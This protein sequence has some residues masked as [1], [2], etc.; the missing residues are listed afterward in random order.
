[1][2][3]TII[4]RGSLGNRVTVPPGVAGVRTRIVM[5]SQTDGDA[6]MPQVWRVALTAPGLSGTWIVV[7]GYGLELEV[8]P[9]A[10]GVLIDVPA[11]P[12][13]PSVYWQT[14][15]GSPETCT[16]YCAPYLPQLYGWE[17]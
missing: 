5:V 8:A 13:G 7:T 11:G 2:T 14:T 15:A 1:M 4:Y 10:G 9:V 12:S 6:G 16:V 3:A 17:P